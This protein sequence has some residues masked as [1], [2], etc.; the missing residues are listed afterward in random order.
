MGDITQNFSFYEFRPNGQPSSWKPNSEYQRMLIIELAKNLQVV[1][2]AMP[3]GAFMRV[4]SGVRLLNDYK[5][6]ITAGYRPSKTSDHNCGIAVPLDPSKSKFKKYGETY[7]FAVGASDVVPNGMSVWDLFKLSFRLVKESM[8]NF[9]QVIYEKNPSDGSE[10]VHYGNAL[11]PFF[12]DK[13]IKMIGRQR[14]RKST[15]GG[16]TYSIV[17]NI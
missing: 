1:R 3:S 12:S 5:R 2:S 9:G 10:W 14:F 4:T 15:D 13:I 6:L 16:I 8:C 17:N 11:E 7:N